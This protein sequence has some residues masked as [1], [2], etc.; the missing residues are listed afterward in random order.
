[1]KR[2]LKLDNFT[3]LAERDEQHRARPDF[4][5][6]EAAVSRATWALPEWLERG[7][8]LVESGGL[9]LGM[10]GRERDDLPAGA[11]RHSYELGGRTRAIVLLRS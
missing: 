5:P 6:F 3:A 9:I 7:A 2:E 8:L 11:T 4:Q 10:E 1:M